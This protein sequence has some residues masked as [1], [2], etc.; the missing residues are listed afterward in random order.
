MKGKN[1]KKHRR[2]ITKSGFQRSV[3]GFGKQILIILPSCMSVLVPHLETDLVPH[4]VIDLVKELVT[5]IAQHF[6]SV[7]DKGGSSLS[8]KKGGGG[9]FRKKLVFKAMAQISQIIIIP[10]LYV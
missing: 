10:F 2:T 8:E 6:V 7:L 3:T 5:D 4:L 1:G 9:H